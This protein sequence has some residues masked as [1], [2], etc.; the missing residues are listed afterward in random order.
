VLADETWLK[1]LDRRDSVELE[2]SILTRDAVATGMGVVQN[3]L[4]KISAGVRVAGPGTLH[5]VMTSAGVAGSTVS[6]DGWC[7]IGSSGCNMFEG[8]REDVE[9]STKGENTLGGTCTR[10]K[11]HTEYQ[12]ARGPRFIHFSL[13]RVHMAQERCWP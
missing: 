3:E 8:G 12:P 9:V 7:P 1:T 4:R 11:L 5:S 13:A 6:M 2:E 10:G